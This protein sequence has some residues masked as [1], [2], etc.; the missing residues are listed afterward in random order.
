MTH[1][2]SGTDLPEQYLCFAAFFLRGHTLHVFHLPYIYKSYLLGVHQRTRKKTAQEQNTNGKH[3]VCDHA[4]KAAN[5]KSS[6]AESL[7]I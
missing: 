5:Q 2:H 6:E 4:K 3:A 1:T 7:N